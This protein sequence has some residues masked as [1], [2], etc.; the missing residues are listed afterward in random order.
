MSIPLPFHSAVESPAHAHGPQPQR[1][2]SDGH[3]AV[4][5]G[6]SMVVGWIVV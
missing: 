3:Q 4:D 1:P 6:R 5:A 2:I